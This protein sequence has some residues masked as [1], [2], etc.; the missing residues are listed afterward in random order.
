M[1][2]NMKISVC[3]I[4]KNEEKVVERC[5]RSVT[6]FADEI[7]VADT[8]SDDKT[9]DIA[10]KFTDKI[11]DFEWVYDFSA[12]R[13]YAFSKAA[14]DYLFWLDADDVI[15]G[16]DA[17]KINELKKEK[18]RADTYMFKY[19][20]GIDSD[21]RPAFTYYRERLM[22]NCKY[23]RFK[24]FVHECVPPFGKIEYRDIAV[25]HKKE[26]PSPPKRN[27]EIFERNIDNG[28]ILNAREQYYYAKEYFYLG[29]YKRCTDEL[30]K[31][32]GMNNLYY[33][34]EWDAMLTMFYCCEKTG[35]RGGEKYL[36][37]SLEKFGPD[38]KTL[39]FLGDYYKKNLKIG[40]AENYYKMAMLCEDEEKNRFREEK[41]EFLEPCLRLVVL[42]FEIG[43]YETAKKYHEMSKNRY[44]NDESVKFNDR[45]FKK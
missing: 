8:G 19:I 16:E 10:N 22:R 32:L 25:I 12:A 1:R 20:A 28:V 38:S 26:K 39:C 45:F 34:D 15:R 14:S 37:E 7:I 6:P 40:D 3:L 36:F 41:Y 9:K 24:G 18:T 21:G 27:L 2:L 23:A 42:Y 11:Y 43:R 17:A 13:N 4:V 29:N 33:A 35:K 30:E 5:L 44:P 31:Y